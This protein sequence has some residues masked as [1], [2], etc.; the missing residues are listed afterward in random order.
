MNRKKLTDGDLRAVQKS[1][2]F[3]SLPHSVFEAVIAQSTI[4]EL[5]PGQ[6]LFREGE[7]ATSVFAVLDGLVKL[8]VTSR[9]GTDVIVEIFHPGTSFAEA[10]VFKQT[11]YPVT[12]T[13]LVQSRVLSVSNKVVTREIRST[14]DAF[15]AILGATYLHLHKL[16]QQIEALKSNTGLERVARYILALSN[17]SAPLQELEIPYEKQILAAFLGIKPE[18][19]S[20][21][22]KRL[23][24]HGVM[25][26]GRQIRLAD[27][28]A[29]ESF[30]EEM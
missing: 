6:I 11:P 21:T 28:A 20:R 16:V 2:F 13:A 9:D 8:S 29:L 5:E 3:G 18:T 12:A 26:E 19:L 30:L 15:G 7:P 27:K 24:A 22:F 17:N 10:L 4:V 23:E 1:L 14:P 25:L